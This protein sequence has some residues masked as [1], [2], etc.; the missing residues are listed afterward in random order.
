MGLASG[1]VSLSDRTS[2]G[3]TNV[4]KKYI[5]K[6]TS[7]ERVDLHQMISAGKAA[8]RK[9]L[10]ARILLKADAS[11]EGPDWTDGQRS[12]G[13]GSKHYRGTQ[14]RRQSSVGQSRR[15]TTSRNTYT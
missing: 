8:A 3:R 13:A 15:Q 14:S 7:H 12:R 1:V 4:N 5:V 11:S 6:L 2:P 9:L 10:H